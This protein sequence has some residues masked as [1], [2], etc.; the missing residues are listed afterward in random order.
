ME[1]LET[2]QLAPA[3][4]LHLVRVDGRELLVAFGSGAPVVITEAARAQPRE[5][6]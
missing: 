5:A 6:F 2:L 4:S 3:Q 1:K